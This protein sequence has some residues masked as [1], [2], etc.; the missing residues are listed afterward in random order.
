MRTAKSTPGAN[1]YR[2]ESARS[3]LLSLYPEL[4]DLLLV[5]SDRDRLERTFQE[6]KGRI[7][8][9]DTVLAGGKRNQIGRDERVVA[10]LVLAPGGI[11]D[12]ERRIEERSPDAGPE[13]Q[14]VSSSGYEPP[15]E[16]P[17]SRHIQVHTEEPDWPSQLQPLV[18]WIAGSR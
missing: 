4:D 10:L 18:E 11:A 6:P 5:L 15:L 7:Q 13:L 12:A 14:A 2:C 1:V 3:H 17:P 16:W 8:D 9:S